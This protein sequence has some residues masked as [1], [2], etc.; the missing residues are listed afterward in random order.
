M[1]WQIEHLTFP[2]S[3]T[4]ITDWAV[5]LHLVMPEWDWKTVAPLF[6]CAGAFTIPADEAGRMAEVLQEAAC[7]P[8]MYPSIV[9]LTED[10]AAA[11]K[12]AAVLGKP[13]RWS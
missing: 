13:W 3:E 10:I 8:R 1:A 7:S 4:D 2:R 5:E 12:Q 9:R 6:D 11:A